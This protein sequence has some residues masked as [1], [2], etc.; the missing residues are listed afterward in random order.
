VSLSSFV[1]L[2]PTA[3]VAGVTEPSIRTEWRSFLILVLWFAVVVIAIGVHRNIPIIDDWTYAWSVERLLDDGRLEVLDWSAVYPLGHALWGAAWSLVLG[4]SFATLRLSTLAFSLLASWALYL[5]LRELEASPRIALLGALSVAANPVVLLL[6][7]SF[8]TDMPFV[9]CTLMALLCYIRA[10]RRG[11]VSLLWWG[12]AWA[13]AAFLDRQIGILTPL[14]A[15]PLLV[16]RPGS[17]PIKRTAVLLALGASWAAMLVGSLA[18]IALVRPTGEMMKL[19]DRLVY[20]I[21]IPLTRYL[22]YNLYVLS[23]IAFY[24]LPALLA[25]ATIR[26]LWRRSTLLVLLVILGALMLGLMGEIPVPLRPGSTWSLDEVGGSRGLING[27]PPVSEFTTIAFAV[28]GAGLLAFA[29]ALM[30][31][32]KPGRLAPLTF[33]TEDPSRS[34][35]GRLMNAVKTIP[36]TTRTPLVIYLVAY[37]VLANIL[38]MYNDRYLIVLLPVIVALALGVR[39]P[40]LEVPRLAWTATAIFAI[41]AVVGT[42]DAL[43][44]NESVRDSWQALVDS[45]VRPSDIDAGYAWTGWILYAHP[46]NLSKGLTVRDVPW[47]TSKRRPTYILSKSPLDGYDIAREVAWTDDALWPGPDRLLVPK[48]RVAN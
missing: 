43:R 4:F 6:S 11:Q 18:I 24:A 47:I 21:Q 17:P 48:R 22:I 36:M 25:M 23:T 3:P 44:F 41:V 19:V 32:A 26:G 28:R 13:F 30:S 7:A 8:M 31:L 27:L 37:L 38:W 16:P 14:A 35:L 29:L 34:V 10:M 33:Q 40:G 15:L 46:E 1:P 5:I 20:V 2:E 39:Q 42:R 9:G 12:G 45:G